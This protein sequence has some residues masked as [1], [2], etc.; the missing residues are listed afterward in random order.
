MAHQEKM[1]AMQ[2]QANQQEQLQQNA[3]TKQ[4]ADEKNMTDLEEAR[5]DA[6]AKINQRNYSEEGTQAII[7]ATQDGINNS[8]KQADLNLKQENIN[9]K[10]NQEIN[11][12]GVKTQELALRARELDI[13]ERG[14]ELTHI[15][16][17]INKN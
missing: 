15:N 9:N 2:I 10:N 12:L 14:Q 16:S 4:L 6:T 13:K 7:K 17:V 8:F 3:F 5:I 1:Q 11:K